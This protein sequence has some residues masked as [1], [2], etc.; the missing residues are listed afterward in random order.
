MAE[1]EN[2]PPGAPKGPGAIKIPIHMPEE[3]A[4]G[5]YS[6]MVAINHS[7]TE[8]TLDFI[9]IQSQPPKGTVASRILMHPVQAKRLLMALQH[10]L[11][12]YEKR[13][14]EIAVQAPAVREEDLL[15]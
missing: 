8:F 5:A 3:T 14:G 4:R 10:N 15:H 7:Q 2:R 11:G 12:H 1:N 6:N 13:F 9:F